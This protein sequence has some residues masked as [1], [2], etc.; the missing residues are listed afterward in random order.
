M[1]DGI[2]SANLVAAKFGGDSDDWN[3]FANDFRNWIKVGTDIGTR[4]V[5]W[6]FKSTTDTIFSM[7]LSEWRID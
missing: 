4:F 3:Y 1:R 2:D 6:K 7:G 5:R